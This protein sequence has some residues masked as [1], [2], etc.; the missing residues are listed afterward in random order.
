MFQELKFQFS[1]AILTILTVAAVVA[2]VINFDQQRKFRLPDDGVTWVDRGRRRGA[3]YVGHDSP[4]PKPGLHAGD[5]LL[6]INGVAVTGATD[7][8]Q[9][10]AGI[11]AWNKAEYQVRRRGVEFKTTVIVARG[12]AGSGDLLPIPG[13][14]RVPDDR[15]VRVFPTRQRA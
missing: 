12:S 3:L 5:V 4:A 7:V 14:G 9:V 1:T 8:P 6:K 11:G 10:L 13:W 2:A 15:S